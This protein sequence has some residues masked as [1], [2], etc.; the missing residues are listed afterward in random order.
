MGFASRTKGLP[1]AN[2]PW[3][4]HHDCLALSAM[5]RNKRSLGASCPLTRTSVSAQ[6]LQVRKLRPK[7]IADEE[8]SQNKNQVC[9]FHVLLIPC[10]RI[11]IYPSESEAHKATDSLYRKAP[12]LQVLSQL[13]KRLKFMGPKQL[14]FVEQNTSEKRMDSF[15]SASL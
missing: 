10:S 6:S 7:D 11:P 15:E 14:S 1:G 5:E 3:K 4:E 2:V 12:L 9:L 8:H 13:I